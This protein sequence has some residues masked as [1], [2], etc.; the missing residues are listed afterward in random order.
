M[1]V[2][3]NTKLQYKYTA[4]PNSFFQVILSIVNL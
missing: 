1:P 4:L 2:M 3:R